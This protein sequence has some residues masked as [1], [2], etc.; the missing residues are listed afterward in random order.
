MNGNR[1]RGG[2][3]PFVL[4]LLAVVVGVVA[5]VVWFRRVGFPG[6]ELF[7]SP[8]FVGA[9]VL[10]V[11]STMVNV[12]LRWARWHF[13]LRR[14]NVRIPARNSLLIYLASMPGVLLPFSLG[15]LVRA[16]LVG[17]SYPAHRLHVVLI[18]LLE[19]ASD[20]V[21][22]AI[23][24]YLAGLSCWMVSLFVLIWLLVVIS[25]R[26][27]YRV[28]MQWCSLGLRSLT[29]CLL[30]SLAS[31]SLTVG[32]LWVLARAAGHGIHALEAAGAFGQSTLTGAAFGVPGGVG[33]TGSALIH[34]LE[35]AGV[36]AA[37]AVPL[38]FVLRAGTVWVAVAI[39]V[40]VAL[41]YRRRL[42]SRSVPGMDEH[43]DEIA[44]E[45]E[46][47]I[48]DHV[49]ERLLGR[50]IGFMKPY[51]TRHGSSG[52]DFGC[53]QGWYLGACAD[54]GLTMS[55]VDISD[56]QVQA[57]RA[58]L[59]ERGLQA[60][61]KVIEGGKLPFPDASFDFVYTINV[62]HHILDD[63]VRA[64]SFRE[65]LRVLRPGGCL[66]MHEINI[67]NPL[68][69]FYMDYVFPVIRSI[70]EGTEKW[71]H[72]KRLPEVDGATWQQEVRYFTFLPDFL[73]GF[74]LTLFAPVERWLERSRFKHWSAHYMAVLVK[75]EEG[76]NHPSLS[77]LEFT[78]R[79]EETRRGS[80]Q[81]C[82]PT[83]VG[84]HL[85]PRCPPRERGL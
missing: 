22:L 25:V 73:P 32:A 33:V 56:G 82:T 53:G 67:A 70:D 52:L 69:R 14:S 40:A 30:L 35:A 43:F 5:T 76:I 34:A 48:P 1:D 18:W 63:E 13:L 75:D 42:L 7:M 20:V 79:T 11:G 8:L 12:L 65:I 61:V 41:L 72:P 23:M 62:V 85:C 17:R 84:A 80:G 74:L 46:E 68:Y 28:S 50:K 45:Y 26:S 24:A 57:A 31:W 44:S 19:R 4:A 21:V 16:P 37:A 71:I 49:R 39:G 55:G 27:Y 29:V 10:L 78:E 60:D 59:D 66:M 58:F 15:E 77:G 83:D 38:V 54:E 64:A 9:I 47:Q 36:S 81:S 51:I 6:T 2:R 3:W